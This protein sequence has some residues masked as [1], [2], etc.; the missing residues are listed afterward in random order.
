MK[1]VIIN[2]IL[3]TCETSYIKKV[4]SIK[5]SMIYNLC[6]E[7]KRQGHEPI[8]IAAADYE[9]EPKEEYDF[10]VVY[11]KTICK[12]IFKL[13]CFPLLKNLEKT[14]R[15]IQPDYIISGEVFSMSS[16][17]VTFYFGKKTIIWH[18]LAKHNNILKK[19][20]SKIWYNV[21]ARLFF[22]KVRVV[23]RSYNALNFISRYCKNVSDE[24]IDHGVDIDKFICCLEKD[25][26]FVVVSQ[27]IKRKH[28]DG[29][30]SCFF[31]FKR[32]NREF[33]L[34][35]IGSGEEEKILKEQVKRLKLQRSVRFLGQKNH[36]EIIPILS[37]AYALI[38]NTEKDNSMLSIV[39][40]IACGTPILTTDIPYNVHYIKKYDLGVVTKRLCEDD[41]LK[42]VS[43]NKEYVL[44][45]FQYRDK[46]SNS[47]HVKQFLRE[48]KKMKGD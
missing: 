36:D 1:V 39:E 11:L 22:R 32:K 40:A 9:P 43:H 5:D 3:Y 38:I 42:I 24:Y 12:K 25:K 41:F 27:L 6:L 4:K 33:E 10:E 8:L 44:N 35:I 29:I 28:I 47:Y 17:C 46:V 7:F 16:L 31:E 19:I 15:N 23:G 45:C 37:K 26:K 30:I 34:I 21:I 14:I 2:P 48:F 20:P 18:E 13:N